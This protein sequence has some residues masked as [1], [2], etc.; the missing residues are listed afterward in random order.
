M[1]EIKKEKPRAKDWVYIGTTGQIDPGKTVIIPDSPA[2]YIQELEKSLE[3]ATRALMQ[4][5]DRRLRAIALLEQVEKH[6]VFNYPVNHLIA[7][8]LLKGIEFDVIYGV[9]DQ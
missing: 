4:R 3:V 7:L 6:G 9:R 8:D 2:Q 5:E 1:S